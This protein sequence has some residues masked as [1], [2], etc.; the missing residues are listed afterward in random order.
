MYNGFSARTA[1][2]DRALVL[3]AGHD[4]SLALKLT[5]NILN[6][7]R[8]PQVPTY[9]CNTSSR[10]IYLVWIIVKECQDTTLRRAPLPRA[11]FQVQ[12][13]K[14]ALLGRDVGERSPTTTG[15]LKSGTIRNLDW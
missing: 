4:P 14:F 7:A 8:E 15:A 5:K 6:V 1:A 12:Q 3:G 10:L 11:Q 2:G 9:A 13:P